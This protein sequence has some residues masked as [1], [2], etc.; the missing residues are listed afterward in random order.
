MS[1]A[2][3]ETE[4]YICGQQYSIEVSKECY[5]AWQEGLLD[6]DV[7]RDVSDEDRE[8]LVT[9]TCDSCWQILFPK[10]YPE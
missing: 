8:L 3:I 1:K 10:G 9:K 5:D 6:D 7:L 2:I 4:C